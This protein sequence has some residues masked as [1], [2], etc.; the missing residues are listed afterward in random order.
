MQLFARSLQYILLYVYVAQ[1]E[2]T[3]AKLVPRAR[4]QKRQTKRISYTAIYS[5]YTPEK[6]H[7]RKR[8]AVQC[9]QVKC[10]EKGV[11]RSAQNAFALKCMYANYVS[12]QVRVSK[13]R[14][15]R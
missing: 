4:F 12:M 5:Q 9:E 10:F 6:P 8:R 2:S 14:A 7:I 3:L 13:V 15:S 11:C 1:Q